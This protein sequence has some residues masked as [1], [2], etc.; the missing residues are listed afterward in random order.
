MSNSLDFFKQVLYEAPGDEA[1]A[2][3]PAEMPAVDNSPP[4]SMPDASPA[5]DL[6]SPP[7]EMPDVGSDDNS[8]DDMGGGMD[9]FGSD[10][11]SN[12]DN[13]KEK[14]NLEI[15]EK[16]SNILNKLL[17]DKFLTLLNQIGSQLSNI[18]NN[19]EVLHTLVP[20]LGEL[21]EQYKRLDE[22]IRLYINDSF[23]Y[24]NSSKNLLFFNQ[25]LN[26]LKLLNDRFSDEINKGTRK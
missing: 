9:D 19:N 15:D 4:D 8:S 1:P 26:A 5:D 25:C 16:I 13:S 10:D 3:P 2:D 7:P 20:N 22:S 18:K 23:L 14:K 17:Y 24:E 12:N 21:T 6:G 11:D